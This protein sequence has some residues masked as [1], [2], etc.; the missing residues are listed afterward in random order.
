MRVCIDTLYTD[1]SSYVYVLYL[2]MDASVRVYMCVA[3]IWLRRMFFIY[4]DIFV[5]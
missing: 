3:M 5:E 1:V 2:F 4:T